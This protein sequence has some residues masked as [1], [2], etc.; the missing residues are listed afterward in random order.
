MIGD[1]VWTSCFLP[2]QR[3]YANFGMVYTLDELC[4]MNGWDHQSGPRWT[5][6]HLSCRD[7]VFPKGGSN[8]RQ[9]SS[10]GVTRGAPPHRFSIGCDLGASCEFI[11]Y[12]NRIRKRFSFK[13]S[14]WSL[15]W[16][17]GTAQGLVS[18]AFG[19]PPGYWYVKTLVNRNG[20]IPSKLN[21][22]GS[23]YNRVT[24]N[25]KMWWPRVVA[26]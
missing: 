2:H 8:Q 19:M 11:S 25:D 18:D 3:K 10:L 7:P 12:N 16:L 5:Q 4:K 13:H 24:R 17:V 20:W 15:S 9:Q 23:N 26:I 6:K 22:N 1:L 14:P 21:Q